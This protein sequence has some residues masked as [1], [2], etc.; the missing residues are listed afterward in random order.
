MQELLT[1]FVNNLVLRKNLGMK[2]KLLI[3]TVL[4]FTLL[5]CNG[6]KN[7]F[8]KNESELPEIKVEAKSYG[9]ALFSLDTNDLSAGLKSIKNEF[10]LFLNANLDDSANINQIHEFVTDTVLIHAFKK[11][12]K[13][14]PTNDFVNQELSKEFSY[15]KYNFPHIQIPQVYTYISGLQYE[16]PVFLQDTIMI[17]ALD[18]YLGDDFLPY[19]GLGLPEYKIRYM[20]PD[21]IAVDVA[22]EFYNAYFLHKEPQ[23]TLLDRM[24]AA[25]KLMY[26]LDMNIP[27][28]PDSV[29]IEY[30]SDQWNWIIKNEKNVWAFLIENDLL[31]SASYKSQSKL[32][33]EG[34][35]TAGFSRSSPSR[36]GVWV[37][38]QIV[39]NYMENNPDVDFKKLIS[40][41]D[42]QMILNKSGYKP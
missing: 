5:S 10:P 13:V 22:K 14:F 28:K 25:G 7:K 9:K 23:K 19:H 6:K 1:V 20:S 2:F 21:Y 34:P 26:F 12:Q 39:R 40:T 16:H 4:V 24:V 36:I 30:T 33:T 27:F 32:M 17:L 3:F 11:S 31:F 15:L 8:L 18:T 35:F 42:S 37:G 29:K 38:W 41:T